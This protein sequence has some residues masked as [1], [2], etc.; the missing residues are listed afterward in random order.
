MAVRCRQFAALLC[1]LALVL[2][3][4]GPVGFRLEITDDPQ[5]DRFV[6]LSV[7]GSATALAAVRNKVAIAVAML[8]TVAVLEAGQLLT[9]DRHADIADVVVKSMGVMAGWAIVLLLQHVRERC[10]RTCTLIIFATV[11]TAASWYVVSP[12]LALE[13]LREAVAQRETTLPAGVKDPAIRRQIIGVKG[14]PL[15]V[16]VWGRTASTLHMTIRSDD[17]V[18]ALL[19]LA[20]ERCDFGWRLASVNRPNQRRFGSG[21]ING[22]DL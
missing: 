1:W 8:T 5:F 15:A 20:F 7:V 21:R 22:H 14:R 2:I 19:V 9:T 17:R 18:R 12:R 13:S 16:D 3:T 6:V 4:L 10:W 11:L